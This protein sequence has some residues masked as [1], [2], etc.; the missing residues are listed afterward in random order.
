MLDIIT[1]KKN[2][3]QNK[4]YCANKK[5][6]PMCEDATA[7]IDVYCGDTVDVIKYKIQAAHL[8]TFYNHI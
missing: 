5:H 3:T 2:P 4:E 7:N 8:I 1:K 6:P